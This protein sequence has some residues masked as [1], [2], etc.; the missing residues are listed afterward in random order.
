MSLNRG[1]IARY[2]Q[3]HVMSLSIMK[4]PVKLMNSF[5]P[6][7]SPAL[8]VGTSNFP[9]NFLEK[10]FVDNVYLSKRLSRT[11]RQGQRPSLAAGC[12]L[13]RPRLTIRPTHQ[14]PC[15]RVSGEA[16]ARGAS[17]RESERQRERE[18][19]VSGAGFGF[20]APSLEI[21][22]LDCVVI[23]RSRCLSPNNSL[24]G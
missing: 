23:L 11:T 1:R 19:S 12:R 3:F 8:L 10:Q 15:R 6:R 5:F 21:K 16:W 2:D 24:E 4:I 18:C 17:G 22:G 9:L 7:P 14:P 13:A 20:V